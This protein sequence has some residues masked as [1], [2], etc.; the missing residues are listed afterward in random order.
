MEYFSTLNGKLATTFFDSDYAT[1]IANWNIE[2]F[3]RIK[4]YEERNIRFRANTD[5]EMNVE[6]RIG[7]AEPFEVNGREYFRFDVIRA[8]PRNPFES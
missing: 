6:A 4:E 5:F 1:F 2:H 7:N 8:F 3:S